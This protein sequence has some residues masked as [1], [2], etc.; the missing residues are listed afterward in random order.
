MVIFVYVRGVLFVLIQRVVFIYTSDTFSVQ[1]IV[2]LIVH[3]HLDAP[4][5]YIIWLMVIFVI[6]GKFDASVIFF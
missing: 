6:Y 2:V 1:H 4:Y 5:L 3:G